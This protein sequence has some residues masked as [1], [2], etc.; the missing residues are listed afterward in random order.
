[1][2]YSG[3]LFR[4]RRLAAGSISGMGKTSLP[5]NFRRH[6]GILRDVMLRRAAAL[7]SIML[8]C[9]SRGTPAASMSPNGF[10]LFSKRYWD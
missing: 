8:A 7:L 2:G 5:G 6:G 10:G 1:M 4:H 3:L 9:C